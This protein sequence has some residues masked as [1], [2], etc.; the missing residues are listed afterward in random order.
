MSLRE[1]WNNVKEWASDID[2]SE[3]LEGIAAGASAGGTIGAVAGG[4]VV[5]W[6]TAP[7]LAG[8]GAGVGLVG[9]LVDDFGRI[10]KSGSSTP[11]NY[12]SNH[13]G[14]LAS[15]GFPVSG[16]AVLNDAFVLDL[17]EVVKA[18]Y[19][20]EEKTLPDLI[21]NMVLAKKRGVTF[22][23]DASAQSTFMLGVEDIRSGIEVVQ[24]G[25]ELVKKTDWESIGSVASSASG[26]LSRW[27]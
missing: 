21:K 13:P 23:L 14:A 15:D 11:E 20:G 2:I 16:K 9:S 25:V 7:V 6:A 5:S 1:R 8:I 26:L 27:K 22:E 12:Y 3:S 19:A 4:G 18:Y 17:I 10:K 24:K